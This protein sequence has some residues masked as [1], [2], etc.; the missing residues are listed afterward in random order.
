LETTHD[1]PYDGLEEEVV[2]DVKELK[3]RGLTPYDVLTRGLV[4]GMDIVGVDFRRGLFV[5]EVLWPLG[6]G[7]HGDLAAA[8]GRDRGA[9]RRDYG[10]RHG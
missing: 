2:A 6:D 8:A 4:A 5:P 10:P 9:E 3:R 1:D 7:G